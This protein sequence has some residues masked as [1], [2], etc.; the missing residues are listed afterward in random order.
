M[1]NTK[2]F[3]SQCLPDFRRVFE[4]CFC[5]Y[6]LLKIY[7]K[8]ASIKEVYDGITEV[9]SNVFQFVGLPS[10]AK[11]LSFLVRVSELS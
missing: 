11:W 9:T 3:F 4:N 2:K 8:H 6:F 7:E 1:T 10:Y 5:I